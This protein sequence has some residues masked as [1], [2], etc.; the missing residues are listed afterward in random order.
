[1]A[2]NSFLLRH[3]MHSIMIDFPGQGIYALWFARIPPTDQNQ[4]YVFRDF[5]STC[6]LLY[7]FGYKSIKCQSYTGLILTKVYYFFG[8]PRF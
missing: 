7:F 3:T 8:C 4:C 5:I 2:A 6:F 1:M